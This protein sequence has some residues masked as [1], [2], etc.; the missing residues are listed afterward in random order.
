[1][2]RTK[3]DKLHMLWSTSAKTGYVEALA[4][5][6]NQEIDGAWRIDEKP[7]FERDGGH[8]M[9][10]KDLQQQYQLVLHYP[11]TFGKEHPRFIPLLYQEGEWKENSG[12][13]KR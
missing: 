3:D 2:I 13:D 4:H 10:F 11:N 1:M 8:G 9:I 6:D 12:D 5:S 7:L